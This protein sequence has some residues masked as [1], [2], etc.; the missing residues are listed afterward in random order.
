MYASGV[1]KTTYFDP[2]GKEIGFGG[3]PLNLVSNLS[4]LS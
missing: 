3:D 4:V 2:D 1:R